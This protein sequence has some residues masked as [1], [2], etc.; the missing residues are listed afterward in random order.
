MRE[1][2]IAEHRFELSRVVQP[3]PGVEEDV[4]DLRED[5]AVV[6]RARRVREIKRFFDAQR[7]PMVRIVLV[8][9]GGLALFNQQHAAGPDGNRFSLVATE[10]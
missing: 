1:Q 5:L 8:A 3:V 4:F 10:G 2:R 9:F 6:R 7:Q